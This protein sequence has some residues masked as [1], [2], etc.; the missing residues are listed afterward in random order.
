MLVFNILIAQHV[1]THIETIGM[2]HM[3]FDAH[4]EPYQLEIISAYK[5]LDKV[6]TLTTI[7]REKYQSRLQHQYSLFLILLMNQGYTL[8]NQKSSLQQVV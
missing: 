2:E 4:P 3:N 7:D 5:N 8:Q 1:P 6:T